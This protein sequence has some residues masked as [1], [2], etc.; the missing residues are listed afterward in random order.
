MHVQWDIAHNLL[1]NS[2]EKYNTT[3]N[4]CRCTRKLYKK[5][6]YNKVLNRTLI[7][8]RG[9]RKNKCGYYFY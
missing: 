7:D 5:Q 4:T 8:N 2:H 9:R 6:Q 1:S 3:Y